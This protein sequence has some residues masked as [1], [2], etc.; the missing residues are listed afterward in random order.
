MRSRGTGNRTPRCEGC[1][2]F[3]MF[4]FAVLGAAGLA[5]LMRTVVSVAWEVPVMV[6]AEDDRVRR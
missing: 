5:A 4:V 3:A 1:S 2:V 6:H